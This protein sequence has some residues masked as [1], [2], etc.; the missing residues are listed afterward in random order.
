MSGTGER[1]TFPCSMCNKTFTR[2]TNRRRHELCVH[3]DER[4]F[5]C[6]SCDRAFKR[7]RDLVGHVNA[8]HKKFLPF[9]CQIEECGRTFARR[10]QL[11]QH[12]RRSHAAALAAASAAADRSSQSTT[13]NHS[14]TAAVPDS[15]AGVA[16]ASAALATARRAAADQAAGRPLTVPNTATDEPIIAL[17]SQFDLRTLLADALDTVAPTVGSSGASGHEEPTNFPAPVPPV[18]GD[19]AIH[20]DFSDSFA[21]LT[22]GVERKRRL[23]VARRDEDAPSSLQHAQRRQRLHVDGDDDDDVDTAHADGSTSMGDNGAFLSGGGGESATTSAL[24]DDTLF[25]FILENKPS[26]M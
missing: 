25:G 15:A 23:H 1:V 9:K 10:E 17:S 8:V 21:P 16:A 11:R 22:V 14:N 3:A 7:K 19:A 18:D 12:Q 20:D 5:D 6:A 26:L 4:R 24:C 2:Q 13:A